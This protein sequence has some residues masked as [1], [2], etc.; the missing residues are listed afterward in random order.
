MTHTPGPWSFGDDGYIWGG[1]D[2]PI[3]EPFDNRP[4]YKGNGRLLAAAPEMLAALRAVLECKE[5]HLALAKVDMPGKATSV[6][7][8]VLAAIAR[9]GD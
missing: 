1:D 6:F 7:D 3:A 8:G 9:A 2:L 5:A 4:E